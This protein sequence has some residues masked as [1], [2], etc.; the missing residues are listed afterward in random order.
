MYDVEFGRCEEQ[1]CSADLLCKLPRQVER[2]AAKIG[3]SQK[4]IEVVG[5]HLEN[6]AE[7][8]VVDK[9]LL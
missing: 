7:M 9:V 8:I 2:D 5:Q 3:I 6:E 4:I 1:Q